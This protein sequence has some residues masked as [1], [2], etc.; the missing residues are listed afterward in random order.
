MPGDGRKIDRTRSILLTS[1]FRARGDAAFT[2]THYLSDPQWFG[3]NLE[4]IQSIHVHGN[5]TVNI[6]TENLDTAAEYCS[7][8]W[9][10]V[11]TIPDDG[12]TD[13]KSN[14]SWKHKGEQVIVCPAVW[15][16][17]QCINCGGRKGPL[18]YRKG[19]N[20]PTII[21]FP[22]HGPSKRKVNEVVK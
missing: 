4:T 6:S 15:R 11:C 7:K 1:L 13:W 19:Q 2:Y 21:S 14:R 5:L 22:S 9:P 17:V 12:T 16:E 3:E 10:T 8:G 18:C 20:R